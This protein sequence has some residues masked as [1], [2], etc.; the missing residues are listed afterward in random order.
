[1]CPILCIVRSSQ[2]HVCL[3]KNKEILHV[4]D[5]KELEKVLRKLLGPSTATGMIKCVDVTIFATYMLTF[6]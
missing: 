4:H 1:M 6:L 2:D 3:D 5:S